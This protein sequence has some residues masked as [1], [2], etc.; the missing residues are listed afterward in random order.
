MAKGVPAVEGQGVERK[1]SDT[2]RKM[3]AQD[4]DRQR[5]ISCRS[6]C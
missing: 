3:M 4:A 1:M 5:E 2:Q 6:G